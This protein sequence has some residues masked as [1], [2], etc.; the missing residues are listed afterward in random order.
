MQEVLPESPYKA[1][2]LAIADAASEGFLAPEGGLDLEACEA[3]FEPEL[4]PL[5]RDVVVDESM[6]D[7]ETPASEM[8][9]H[10]VGRYVA[11]DLEAREK[12]LKRQ[13]QEPDADLQSLLQER[14]RLLERKRASVSASS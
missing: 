11:K 8:L 5:L 3:Q 7:Q 14:Q 6:L 12:E 13:M 1:L 4:V 2:A 10:L 9:V